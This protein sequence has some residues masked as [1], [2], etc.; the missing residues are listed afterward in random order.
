MHAGIRQC[1]RPRSGA[2]RSGSPRRRQDLSEKVQQLKPADYFRGCATVCTRLTRRGVEKPPAVA[3]DGVSSRAERVQA[4]GHWPGGTTDTGTGKEKGV[5][6][7][8]GVP[9]QC[10]GLPRW[11]RR[12][13]DLGC[14][15][16]RM[17]RRDCPSGHIYLPQTRSS[18]AVRN[19]T[20][21]PEMVSR[22]HY[23]VEHWALWISSRAMSMPNAGGLCRVGSPIK[24]AIRQTRQTR[25]SRS[26]ARGLSRLTRLRSGAL[27]S[28]H[29][30]KGMHLHRQRLYRHCRS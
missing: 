7:G 25:T 8:G 4:G 28:A 22:Q 20:R 12:G 17:L 24:P 15:H 27:A 30:S 16:P 13:G 11:R 3:G 26:G 29:G 6:R 2:H 21:A 1:P 14:H 23:R 18:L 5:V 9:A 19:Q 10:S